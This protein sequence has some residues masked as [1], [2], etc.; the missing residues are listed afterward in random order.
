[1]TLPFE[2]H[3]ERLGIQGWIHVIFG[4]FLP[5]IFERHPK[6]TVICDESG[7]S[8]SVPN[9]KH[10]VSTRSYHWTDVIT[11]DHEEF[12]NAESI[13]DRELLRV[14]VK[15]APGPDPAR[16]RLNRSEMVFEVNSDSYGFVE[17]KRIFEAMTPHVK[18]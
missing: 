4:G 16:T 18:H 1:M 10:D 6:L 9:G 13:T 14:Y 17:L 3:S 5:L 2:F 15:L 11:I 12:G 8:V 7:F